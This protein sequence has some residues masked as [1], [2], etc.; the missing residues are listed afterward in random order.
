[1]NKGQ[2]NVARK[3]YIENVIGNAIRVKQD[4][5]YLKYAK[6]KVTEGE[7]IRIGDTLGRAVTLNVTA[8]SLEEILEDISRVVLAGKEKVSPPH[9]IVLD[10]DE[11]RAI[12]HLFREGK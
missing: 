4:F 1:M 5:D 3:A 6:T 9:S 11:L 12:A 7:Y 8:L 10:G 2:M